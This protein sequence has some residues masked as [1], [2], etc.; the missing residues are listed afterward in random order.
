MSFLRRPC[1][2]VTKLR[3]APARA[4][5]GT[6][7]QRTSAKKF[8]V[9]TGGVISGIGKGVTAS[10]IGVILKMMKLRPTAIKIDPYLNADAGTMSPFEHGE[11]FVLDDGGE[12]DLDLGNYERFLDVRLK[13]NSNLTTGKIY[14]SVIAK[15]RKGEYLGKT[16]Q[17]IPHITNEIIERIL[18]VSTQSVD[19]SDEE[20]E[21]CVIELGGTI[22]DIESM[23]F[24]E[25]L[26]QLQLKVKRENF[27]LVHVS[28]VPTVGNPGE[29]K[30]KPTQHSVKELRSLGLAPD[31]IVCRSKDDVQHHTKEKISLFC[32]VPVD[33]VLSICDVSNIYQVPM[34]MLGQQF[35]G[36]LAA[37]L[38]LKGAQVPEAEQEHKT[39]DTVDPYAALLD[40]DTRSKWSTMATSVDKATCEASIALVGKYTT[41][42]DSY[43]SVISALKHACIST[44]QRLNLVMVESSHL[45]EECAIN[46]PE[47]HRAAWDKLHSAQG[48]LVPGGF[49]IRGIEGK[50]E[51]IR[52]AREKKIPFLGICLG[53][54]AAVIEY[55]RTFLG[56]PGANSC[57]F[58]QGISAEDSAIIFMPE[59]DTEKMGGTMRLGMRQSILEPNSKAS[60]LYG[61]QPS[62]LERH[63]H[64]YEVNPDFV[65]L[66]EGQGLR[67]SGKDDKGERMEVIELP[68]ATHPY[69]VAVQFH[70]EF[71]SRPMRPSPVFHGLLEAVKSQKSV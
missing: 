62:V 56:R 46:E 42:L 1:A 38:G 52:F 44:S 63:R 2:V 30:T 51:A 7:L 43:L 40:P 28:M 49:G 45:E 37:R 10:S 29:Q 54:Q 4:A 25:A 39:D 66:L 67:F 27:C 21:V 26:R 20:P 58:A 5:S 19:G 6:A 18:D 35:H 22:G 36:L 14:Q 15:E 55:C 41:Q 13:S 33:N 50:V 3:L 61:G 24:V 57:E 70:P 68:S 31:F 11:V 47:L 23:P 71:L 12:T 8:I 34:V 48:I 16:V 59:G 69:F 32:N 65:P 9:V 60:E 64:R 53:M 17:I